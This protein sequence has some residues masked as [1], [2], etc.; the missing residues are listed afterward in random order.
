MKEMDYKRIGVELEIKKIYNYFC[1]IPVN[2]IKF[3]I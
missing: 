3:I 2:S 1:K